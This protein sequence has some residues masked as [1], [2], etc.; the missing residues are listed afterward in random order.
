MP[1]LRRE[2]IQ[3]VASLARFIDS[4]TD[5]C[6]VRSGA[7]VHLPSSEL[8]FKY[9][10]GLA[11]AT[12]KYVAK[13]LAQETRERALL[14][15]RREITVI[16]ADWRFLHRYIKPTLDADTLRLPTALLD[17]LQDRFRSIQ[18]FGSSSFI[19][20]HSADFNYISVRL[21][22]FR[23]Y[24]DK[25]ADIIGEDKFPERLAIIGIPYSQSSSLFMNCLIPHELGHH[26]FAHSALSERFA[27]QFEKELNEY[28]DIQI[29][30]RTDIVVSFTKW[31]E[32]IF[33]DLFA[34][35]MFGFCFSFAYIELFDVSNCLDAN[36]R[37]LSRFAAA[38]GITNFSPEYPPDLLRLRQQ[39]SLLKT[40]GWLDDVLAIDSHYARTL[41]AAAG[42]TDS[43]FSWHWLRKTLP[44]SVDCEK[45]LGCFFSS[46]PKINDAMEECT[47]GL[48]VAYREW[49][50]S[51][52]WIEECLENGVV[53]SSIRSRSRTDPWPPAP[54]SLLNSAYRFYAQS[55][56]KLLRLIEGTGTDPVGE[57]VQ[58]SQK[59]E[60]WTSKAIEDVLL[61]RKRLA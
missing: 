37:F 32:E 19:L 44:D 12:K 58:W 26:V 24:A 8:F 7:C 53:P 28:R 47:K 20:F 18:R 9:I 13:S 51:S 16:R 2:L 40:D 50:S 43:Q 5:L 52:K 21:E 57:R 27:T 61:T 39:T 55:M 30:M 56:P 41:E 11:T 42:L 3:D 6:S 4:V 1:D 25:L 10:R 45:V 60:M 36:D 22:K 35:R 34:V 59:I 46:L 54:V 49:S 33:C 17:C 31:V 38:R 14:Q 48:P 23:E 15:L 29:S